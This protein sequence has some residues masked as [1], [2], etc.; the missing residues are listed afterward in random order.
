MKNKIRKLSIIDENNSIAIVTV[1]VIDLSTFLSH[2]RRPD[3]TLLILRTISRGIEPRCDHVTGTTE[4]QWCDD[5]NR[6]V[7]QTCD[8]EIRIVD[9]HKDN[10]IKIDGKIA[11]T[12]V[13]N[14]FHFYTEYEY[15][16]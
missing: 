8:D 14:T 3:L 1:T 9:L 2:T 4:V 5:R 12:C 15:Y 11:R 6:F 10:N 16:F 13:W 7:C